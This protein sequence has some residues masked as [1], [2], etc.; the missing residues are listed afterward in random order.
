[1]CIRDSAGSLQNNLELY[2]DWEDG[3]IYLYCD[4]GNPGEYFDSVDICMRRAAVNKEDALAITLDNISFKYIGE[5]GVA[6]FGCYDFHVQ[7]CTLEW[8]GGA[9][10]GLDE[11]GGAFWFG[12]GIHNWADCDGFYVTNCYFTHNYD[13]CV[14]S[15]FTD[16]SEDRVV[17]MNNIEF[18][19]NVM[20]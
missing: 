2:H 4:Y 16:S 6:L 20:E 14:T 3:H 7:N 15:Q 12:N 13:S 1:M 11:N 18:G 19:N 5:C 8:I 10:Q 9:V 17:K